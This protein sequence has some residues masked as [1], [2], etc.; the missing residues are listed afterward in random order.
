[1]FGMNSQTGSG[2]RPVSTAGRFAATNYTLPGRGFSGI[3]VAIKQA[4]VFLTAMDTRTER[5]S[6]PISYARKNADGFWY[7]DVKLGNGRKERLGPYKTETV[8]QEFIKAQLAAW[9]E[10]QKLFLKPPR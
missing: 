5:V 3:T 4:M 7:V 2:P 6:P 1:M 8:A 10:G 9:H